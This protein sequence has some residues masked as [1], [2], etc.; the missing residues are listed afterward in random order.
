[1]L[2]QRLLVQPRGYEVCGVFRVWKFKGGKQAGSVDQRK[3]GIWRKRF[4]FP[5]VDAEALLRRLGAGWS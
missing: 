4:W 5:L 3:S 1:M 2:T